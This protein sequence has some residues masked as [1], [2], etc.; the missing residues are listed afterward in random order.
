VRILL[1]HGWLLEGT[2]S[3]IYTA[4]VS[5]AWRDG[6]HEVL[7]VCQQGHPDRFPFVDAW[8]TA[9]GEGVSDLQRTGASGAAGSAILLRPDIGSL[10]PVFVYDEYE[11]FRVKRFVDL[12]DQELES[13][14]DL[15]ADAL[16]AIESWRPS[17][18]V[19]AGH[20][21]AGPVAV[22]RAGGEG[23]YVAKI[24]GSDIE[25]AAR[26]QDRYAELARWGLEGARSVAG[27]SRDV[28]ARA[29]AVAPSVADR[30]RVVHPGVDV[31]R[32]RPRPR[33]EALREA[34]GRLA[35]DPAIA[36]GRP[37]STD[38][39]ALRLLSARDPGGLSSL[40]ASYDQTAP[41]PETPERLG[42]LA[43]WDGPMVG[44][45]GKLVPQKGVERFLQAVA[46][47][48]EDV[49]GVVVGF[50]TFREWL[51]ALVAALD[52]GNHAAA[53]WL[54]EASDMIVELSAAE[55]TGAAG[56]AER[57]TFTGRLDH[58]YAPEVVAGLDV[59]VV[60]S[61][62]KEAFGMVAAEAASAGAVPLVARHS[63]LAE[64]AQALE[65]SAGTPGLLSFEPGPGSTHRLVEGLRRL[66]GMTAEERAALG[67]ALR[68]HV[69]SEWTWERTA[70]RLLAAALISP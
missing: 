36:R 27:G 63:S 28:L 41:D 57:V 61:T 53:G 16:R 29:V 62:G 64:V 56:L 10:L 30:T 19:I 11:G 42:M 25:Y 45:L 58:R 47:L 37:A 44:Y 52:E 21:M 2:G 3:N 26:L 20:A 24:H 23:R 69:V 8:G 48:G 5:E 31:R 9:S 66:L 55:V 32:W 38:G 17:D 12:T 33:G 43:D 51:V 39:R 14:L 22:R 18:A 1:W 46:L 6:G 40:A 35:S 54:G 15:N 7:V 49:R 50:G 4:M 70:D 13:Y 68:G 65:G 67:E 60:P 59:L 34:A